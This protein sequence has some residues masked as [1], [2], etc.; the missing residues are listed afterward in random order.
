ML[1]KSYR[2]DKSLR[3]AA[4]ARAVPVAAYEPIQKHNH[5]GIPGWLKNIP[6]AEDFRRYIPLAK[7]F[8]PKNT[9]LAKESGLKKLALGAAHP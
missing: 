6:L 1:F 8:L 4:E 7:K 5:P 9:P 2:A 3:P